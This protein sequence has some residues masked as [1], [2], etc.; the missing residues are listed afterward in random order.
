VNFSNRDVLTVFYC[1]ITIL[2]LILLGF[3]WYVWRQSLTAAE[4]VSY[5]LAA[6]VLLIMGIALIM[7][8]IET[9]IFRDDPDVWL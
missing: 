5:C 9:Y 3:S 7:F 8:G 1:F 2:G 4:P 6:I